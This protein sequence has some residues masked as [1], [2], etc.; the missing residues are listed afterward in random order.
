MGG[1]AWHV[2]RLAPRAH[3]P[4]FAALPAMAAL[5]VTAALPAAARTGMCLA[6][7]SVALGTRICRT[8][9]WAM[10]SIASA[11]TWLGRVIDRRNAP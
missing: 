7:T 10:A 3:R 8:P 9:S 6:R 4:F 1:G 5:P 11:I 2:I